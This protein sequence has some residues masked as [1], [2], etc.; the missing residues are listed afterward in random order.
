MAAAAETVPRPQ[1]AVVR[2]EVKQRRDWSKLGLG[3]YFALFLF[4]L[5]IPMILMAILS[6]QGPTGQLTFPF[7]GPF[8]LDWW[9]TL[10]DTSVFNTDRRRRQRI[11]T[12]VALAQPRR[13]RPRGSVR[14]LA[15]D[16]VPP[17]LAVED[18]TSSPSTSSCSR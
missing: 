17:P 15:V 6:F 5:Y 13:G 10:F 16:G 18:A 7:R 8:S 12:P 2:R 4:F 11:G 1:D 14:V 9:K 3:V